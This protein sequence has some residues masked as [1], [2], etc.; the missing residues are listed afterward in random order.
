MRANRKSFLYSFAFPSVIIFQRFL[1][2][3]LY[4]HRGGDGEVVA[5][6][7]QRRLNIVS[8]LMGEILRGGGDYT[9]TRAVNKIKPFSWLE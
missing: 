4:A 2:D 1:W 6:S 5:G 7:Q 8:R 3:A 9:W